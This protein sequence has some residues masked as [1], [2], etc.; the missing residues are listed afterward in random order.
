MHWSFARLP[1]PTPAD[2]GPICAQQDAIICTAA[3]LSSLRGFKTIYVL[4]VHAVEHSARRV[5]VKTASARNMRSALVIAPL[6]AF[7]AYFA[8]GYIGWDT[9]VDFNDPP[10]IVAPHPPVQTATSRKPFQYGEFELTPVAEYRF[11]AR[12]IM[13]ERYWTDQFSSASPID[14]LIGWQEGS[15]TAV[16]KQ[17]D[18][19]HSGRHYSYIPITSEQHSTRLLS[20]RTANVHVIPATDEVLK[21][22]FT[23][24]PGDVITVQG[25]L[26]GARAG[27]WK[28]GTSTSRSDTGTGACETMFVEQAE[29]NAGTV[30]Q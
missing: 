30:P 14:L 24:R 27:N 26:V 20:S 4:C 8:A 22:L 10:G 12:L 2:S 23:F 6:C 15:D 17:A 11:T 13:S 21:T 3:L 28:W 16:L 25:L 29:L 18:W 9:G 19:G 7:A 5:G 1:S